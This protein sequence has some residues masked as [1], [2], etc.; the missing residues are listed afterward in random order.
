M[1]AC[2]FPCMYVCM[3]LSVYIHEYV[4][5]YVYMHVRTCICLP[6]CVCVCV[7]VCMRKISRSHQSGGVI[8]DTAYTSSSSCILNDSSSLWHLDNA[9]SSWYVD[10]SR[11]HTHTGIKLECIAIYMTAL[12]N[13]VN[14][15][16]DIHS[17]S[18]LCTH[19]MHMTDRVRDM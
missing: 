1:Y 15:H 5:T 14:T 9:S 11:P 13:I 8:E 6:V 2:L 16:F 7:C 19:T 4:S 12:K 3:C 17:D 18:A 10:D